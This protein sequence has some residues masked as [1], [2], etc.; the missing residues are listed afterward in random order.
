MRFANPIFLWLLLSLPVLILGFS[1]RYGWRRRI[2]NRLG[3]SSQIRTLTQSVSPFTR[4]VKAMLICLSLGMLIIALAR[5]QSGER[6]TL[7][8][9]VPCTPLPG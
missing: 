7:A 6:T 5:P 2:L 4:V 8:P 9:T 1:L 3:N